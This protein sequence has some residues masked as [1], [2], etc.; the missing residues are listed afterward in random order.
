MDFLN[1]ITVKAR[2]VALFTL[3]LVL[4]VVF[5]GFTLQKIGTLGELTRFLYDHPLQVSNAALRASTGVVRIHRN[6][7]DVS[8]SQSKIQTNTAV[9]EVNLEVQKVYQELDLVEE[10]ILGDEGKKLIQ[11]TIEMFAGWKQI[12]LEVLELVLKGDTVAANKITREKGADYVFRL[13]RKMQELNTYAHNKA[14]GFMANVEDTHQQIDTMLV[15][16]IALVG[17]ICFAA[18]FV[19]IN[20]IDR[21]L[22][23][24]K[25]KMASITSS[26]EMSTVEMA[27]KNEITELASHFN[28]LMTVLKDQV[29]LRDGINELNREVGG[30]LPYKDLAN[31]SISFVARTLDSCA[32]ALYIYDPTD[33]VC[34]LTASFAF[35]ERKYLANHFAL[36]EGIVGQ[37]AVE[38]QPILLKNISRD[39]ACA[40]TG[41][42][43]EPPRNIYTVPI[44]YEQELLAIME[45]ASF[46]QIDHMKKQFVEEAA[47]TIAIQLNVAIQR[48]R[49]NDLLQESQA[50]NVELQAKTDEINAGNEKLAATN[51]ELQA[52]SQELQAQRDELQAQASELET[53][54]LQVEEANRLKSEFLSNMSH[55]LR[56]PLNSIMS[57]SQLLISRGVDKDPDKAVEYLH[58]ID[59][60]GRQ[61]LNLINDILDLTKVES[62]RMEIYPTKFES[63]YLV[64]RLLQ[65]TEPLAKEKHLLL[66]KNIPKAPLIFSDEDKIYQILLNFLSNAIKF[67]EKGT[68]TMA[69]TEIDSNVSFA[70]SDTGMGIPADDLDNIFDEFRQVDGSFTREHEGTGLGLAISKKLAVLLGGS[71]TVKSVLGSGSTFTL[72]LPINVHDP[73]PADNDSASALLPPVVSPATG[74]GPTVLVIDDDESARTELSAYLIADGYHVITAGSGKEGLQLARQRQP[75]VICLDLLMP[76]MDGWE[77]LRLLK[78]EKETVAIPVIITSVSRDKETG[79]ALGAVGYVSKPVDSDFLLEEIRRVCGKQ[80]DRR[81][82]VV[83]DDIGVQEFLKDLLEEKGFMVETAGNG[84]EALE[85]V[86]LSPPHLMVLDLLMPDVDGFTVLDQL[87]QKQATRDLP[88]I[89]LTDKDLTQD[90]FARLNTAVETIRKD[91]LNKKIFLQHIEGALVSRAAKPSGERSGPLRILV[92]EDNEIASQQLKTALEENGFEVD[93]AADGA[94]GLEKVG[95]NIPDGIVL[96]LMMPKID[97]FQVL[98]QIRSRPETATLPVLILT[99]KELSNVERNRLTH[100]NIQQLIQKGVTDRDLLVASVRKML[101]AGNVV[102]KA[103]AP[104]KVEGKTCQSVPGS[105][106]LV[107]DN[108]DNRLTVS[109][110]LDEEGYDLF[111]ADDGRQG[112]EA[113]REKQP[114]LVLMDIQLPV[115]SGLDAIKMIKDDPVTKDIPIIAVTA[116]VMKGDRESVLAAGADDYIAKPIDPT[117]MI[118]K[119]RKWMR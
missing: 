86:A 80:P 110:I 97:G 103:G 11:E 19:V 88:V 60:N 44:I 68:V 30:D 102:T 69:V 106:L 31:K 59:R 29:W 62:G 9:Q 92:V 58:V 48:N 91:K 105:I 115:L 84:R 56:T 50:A 85:K 98:E 43:S 109:A 78:S 107:E 118:N 93:V 25:D 73:A 63:G 61:L 12:R 113:A 99:A 90:D 104:V 23:Y 5:G 101:Y 117:E 27:G 83:E 33:E 16:A 37:V 26:G 2:I 72:T 45:V 18:A 49:I 14:N 40:N 95:Q 42:V 7:K 13:E 35:V 8:T 17:L 47:A 38:K 10:L 67:T 114:D 65:T 55:E 79:W 116:R 24:L 1:K 51:K 74:K 111:F 66:E 71:I 6:M 39:E 32:A 46:E 64:E 82:L 76:N 81:L 108:P 53:K 15:W 94:E 52:Q 36:G 119:V 34:N 96:D 75:D 4:L 20:S 41:T 89:I 100:N 3:T 87:R 112:V 70:I 22:A 28:N 57:L 21:S 54:R 77:V